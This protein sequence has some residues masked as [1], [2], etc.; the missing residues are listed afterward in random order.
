MTSK[1]PATE[2]LIEKTRPKAFSSM[3][4][5]LCQFPVNVNTKE[6]FDA[7]FEQVKLAQLTV[8]DFEA[9]CLRLAGTMQPYKP[10]MAA[11]YLEAARS[12]R[13][14]RSARKANCPECAG[15]GW[16]YVRD[17]RDGKPPVRVKNEDI[18]PGETLS[19]AHCQA[20][21]AVI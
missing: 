4:R 16:I 15:R 13:A 5:I 9:A 18:K 17:N 21:M 10:P 1:P 20:C 2:I 12:I 8:S 6:Y 3:R 7:I 14:G 19:L 11:E